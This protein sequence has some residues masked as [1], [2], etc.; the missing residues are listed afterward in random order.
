MLNE[1]G[2]NAIFWF[3]DYENWGKKCDFAYLKL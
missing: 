2:D 1:I 3:V